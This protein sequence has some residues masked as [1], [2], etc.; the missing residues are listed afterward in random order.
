M[1]NSQTH[2]FP[3]AEGKVYDLRENVCRDRKMEDYFSFA[4]MTAYNPKADPT[5]LDRFIKGITVRDSVLEKLLQDIGGYILTGDT[6]LKKI[7]IPEGSG[8]NG[9]SLL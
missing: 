9:K 3:L 6:S 1:L 5:R 4:S 7:F 8:N 2:L